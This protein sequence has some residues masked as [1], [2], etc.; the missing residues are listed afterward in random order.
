VGLVP[1][2]IPRVMTWLASS[3]RGFHP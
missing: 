2:L 3:L 1:P